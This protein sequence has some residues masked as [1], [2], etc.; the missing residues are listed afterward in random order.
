MKAYHWLL[1]YVKCR[2]R[3]DHTACFFNLCREHG[4]LYA[5]VRE[6]EADDNS[7]ACRISLSQWK[8]VE[9]ACR[10]R[11]IDARV[12]GRGGL[13]ML[14]YRYRL[15]VGLAVGALLTVALV[16]VAGR[17]VWDVRVQ[18]EAGVNGAELIEQLRACGLAVGTWI[19]S[20]ETDDVESRLLVESDDIAWV[21]VNMKG[22][23]AYVQVRALKQPHSTRTDEPTNLVARCEG[24][25]ESVKLISGEV[26]V[27]VGDLV[28]EGE[29]LISGVRDSSVQGYGVSSAQGEVLA[30]TEHI[31]TVKVDRVSEQKVY[32]GQKIAQKTLF[33][34]GKAIKIQKSTGIIE[35]NCD[36][37]KRLEI[38]DLG[39]G[40]RL[41]VSM[42]TVVL[43][44]YV[45]EPVTLDD[46]ALMSRA[47]EQLGGALTAAT[48]GAMLVSKQVSTELT[49]T[50]ALLTCRYRCVE[51]IAEPLVFDV[52][53]E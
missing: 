1:G 41:P 14:F 39:K 24:V 8:N 33:F 47:Y 19:P 31:L 40:V 48:E 5:P 34:F 44:T 45:T 27:Q 30:R 42:E 38:F 53:S 25:I 6:R 18:S 9:H 11:G 20:V 4:F 36:T 17:V 2:V 51:N 29:L 26:S 22:T 15:R 52:Q 16:L 49:D 13:P 23:V 32:T 28:R 35:G 50:G 3:C 37:I 46:E 21:S 7:F 10:S 12:I 43:Q